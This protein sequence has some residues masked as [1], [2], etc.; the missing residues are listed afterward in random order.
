MAGR[1]I[2]LAAAA[3]L[4]GGQVV[5]HGDHA[6]SGVAPLEEAGPSH[7][8]FLTSPRYLPSFRGSAA[9]A[10]LLTPA[11]SATMDGPANRIVVADPA[12]AMAAVVAAL[13]PEPSRV[14][15][16]DPTARLAPGVRLGE[17]VTIAAHAVLG[18]G[19]RL[20]DRVVVG[21]GAVLGPG[22]SIGEDTVLGPHVTCDEGTVIGR[23]CRIKAGAVLGGVGFG[24]LPGEGGLQRVPHV[25]R[26]RVEDDCDIGANSCVDRGSV[27]DTVIG[28]GTRL[29]NLVHVGH[30]VRVGKRCLLMAQVGIAGSARIGDDVILAGQV[31]VSGHLE[32]G[33]RARVSAQA[34]VA[35]DLPGGEDYGGSPARPHRE[36]LRSTAVLYG[37]VPLAR[38]LKTIVAERRAHG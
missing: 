6:V 4:V 33:D 21:A 28:A 9:G 25:G 10:V 27:G 31:G 32:V 15:A 23:R 36:W 11:L 22:V 34:G 38:D 29:D 2:T 12:L 7:L 3:E 16:I 5:G 30:N 14:P 20:G 13:Y 24:Y 8:S 37:M 19:V 26:C 18:E 17:G 35:S 1:S